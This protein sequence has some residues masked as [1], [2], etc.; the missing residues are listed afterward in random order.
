MSA[1]KPVTI[2]GVTYESLTHAAQ[3]LGVTTQAI[4]NRINPE[5]S[6]KAQRAYRE[7]HIGLQVE[8]NALLQAIRTAERQLKLCRKHNIGTCA[9]RQAVFSRI[10]ALH[11]QAEVYLCEAPDYP[12]S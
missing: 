9:Q 8:R 6:Q 12:K 4:W 2:D 7:R 1:K 11:E 5:A 3:A 10:D